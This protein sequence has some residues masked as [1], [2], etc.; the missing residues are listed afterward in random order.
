[1]YKLWGHPKAY[2][3]KLSL[4]NILVKKGK[5]SYFVS[6]IKADIKR[7]GVE[8]ELYKMMK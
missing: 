4:K 3:T 2:N 5:S 7:V 1:M 6:G 8:E